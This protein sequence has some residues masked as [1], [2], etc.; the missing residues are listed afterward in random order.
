MGLKKFNFNLKKKI[1]NFVDIG[2]YWKDFVKMTFLL[3]L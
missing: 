1:D 3:Q 2:P